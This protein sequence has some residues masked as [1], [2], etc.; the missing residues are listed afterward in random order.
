MSPLFLLLV[1][2]IL[3]LVAI[4]FRAPARLTTLLVC[5]ANVLVVAVSG[6]QEFFKA[7][8]FEGLSNHFLWEQS[9]PWG[10]LPGLG[11]VS[12]KVGVDGISFPLVILTVVVALA[13]VLVT[14]PRVERERLFYGNLLL[15][16]LGAL[17]AFVSL[18]LFFLY[19][20]HEVAL[21]PT[22]LLIGMWGHG[23]RRVFVSYQTTIYL[24]AGSLAILIGFLILLNAMPAAHRTTDLVVLREWFLNQPLSR[25][26]QVQ[27]YAWLLIGFGILVGLFPF[28]GWAPPAYAASPTG[29]AMLHAGVLKKFGIYALLRIVLPLFPLA[30]RDF[31]FGENLVSLLIVGNLLVIGWVTIAQRRLDQMLG[32]SSVMHMGYLFLGLFAASQLSLSGVVLLMVGHGLSVSGLFAINGVLREKVN[33]SDMNRL[34]GLAKYFPFFS[35]AFVIFA[36]AS[37]GLPGLANFPG[38]ILI[39]FGSWKRYPLVTIAAL[40]GVVISSIYLL[41]AVKQVFFGSAAHEGVR[42]EVFISTKVGVLILL[43]SVLGW[44]LLPGLSSQKANASLSHWLG[45]DALKV[46]MK[47]E[48]EF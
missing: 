22:F 2:P 42:K 19:V 7:H 32:F 12:F 15:V 37:I 48:R 38:E 11:E 23:P 44:G 8:S 41:R 28:H 33:E 1:L 36:L 9:I 35:F 21:I 34:G 14:P 31:V 29:L 40:F 13:A 5:V 25:S 46:A 24:L 45:I 10:N 4:I 6:L 47:K 17:G 20:F 18:D 39:F 3:G 27:L 43:V 26:T 16:I 30:P